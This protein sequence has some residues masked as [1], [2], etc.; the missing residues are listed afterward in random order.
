MGFRQVEEAL[1]GRQLFWAL[2]VVGQCL[3]EVR[4]GIPPLAS[5]LGNLTEAVV[6]S[7]LSEEI[8]R[9]FE[10]ADGASVPLGR[11]LE[12]LSNALDFGDAGSLDLA[13]AKGIWEDAL[14]RRMR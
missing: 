3:L 9:S 1:R 12:L 6:A 8:S 10:S 11:R 7:A 13:D 14:P 2:V 5:G 4:D